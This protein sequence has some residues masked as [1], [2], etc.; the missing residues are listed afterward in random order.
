MMLQNNWKSREARRQNAEAKSREQKSLT[1]KIWKLD[2]REVGSEIEAENA[3]GGLAHMFAELWIADDL[4]QGIHETGHKTFTVTLATSFPD[5][6]RS[7]LAGKRL[8]S[9]L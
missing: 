9:R 4:T 6:K 5:A 3:L 2:N 8:S 7:R 1:R